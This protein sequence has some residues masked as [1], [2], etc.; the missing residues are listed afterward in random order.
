M[1]IDFGI[2]RKYNS[3]SGRDTTMFATQ[4]FAPPEQFG[5]AQTD[6]RSDIY[7]LGAVFRYILTGMTRRDAPVRNK[8][9]GFIVQKCTA[10]DP[11][12]RFQSIPELP[13]LRLLRIWY[14]PVA[15]WAPLENMRS[16]Q[17]FS[18]MGCYNT[19]SVSCL[20]DISSLY[21]LEIRHSDVFV[22]LEGIQYIPGL[23]C[24]HITYTG[25]RDFSPLNDT[26]ALPYLA[27]LAIS[28]DMQPY[29][30]TFT[31]GGVEVIIC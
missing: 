19:R 8:V 13:Y 9:L 12:D 29:L 17:I 11:K 15:D 3:A 27:R 31:R 10:L 20:G 21:Y 6:T 16:L 30:Y 4:E 25:V 14:S 5:F 1:L 7:S 2:S 23:I 22:C 18:L 26:N 24:L 28:R